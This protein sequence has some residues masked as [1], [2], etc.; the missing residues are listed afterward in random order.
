MDV[1]VPRSVV[2]AGRWIWRLL[3]QGL[4]GYPLCTEYCTCTEEE[5]S[6]R[7]PG[8]NVAQRKK[9]EEG[10]LALCLIKDQQRDSKKSR[11]VTVW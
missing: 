1:G 9:V 7:S 2:V 10:F 4:V 5:Y 3:P 11:K 8:L 6:R